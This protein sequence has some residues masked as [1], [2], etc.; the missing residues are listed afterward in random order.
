MDIKDII[1]ELKSSVA[2]LEAEMAKASPDHD[3][4][5]DIARRSLRPASDML[6]EIAFKLRVKQS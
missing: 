3:V 6:K 2:K 5:D 4:I 1:T